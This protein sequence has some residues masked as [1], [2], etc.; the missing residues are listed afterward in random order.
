MLYG[1]CNW[2]RDSESERRLVPCLGVKGTEEKHN[3]EE[4]HED[5]DEDQEEHEEVKEKEEDDDDEEEEEEGEEE[6]EEEE[7]E[8]EEDVELEVE[9]V[10]DGAEKKGGRLAGDEKE[11]EGNG[12]MLANEIEEVGVEAST[13]EAAHGGSGKVMVGD[14]VGDATEVVDLEAR[15]RVDSLASGGGGGGDGDDSPSMKWSK[16]SGEGRVAFAEGHGSSGKQSTSVVDI[17]KKHWATIGSQSKGNGGGSADGGPADENAENDAVPSALPLVAK[18]PPRQASGGKGVSVGKGKGKE[19]PATKTATGGVARTSQGP[20]AEV[21][22]ASPIHQPPAGGRAP[23]GPSA[24]KGD[25]PPPAAVPSAAKNAV[26]ASAARCTGKGVAAENA[27]KAQLQLL[28]SRKAVQQPPPPVNATR[29]SA[30]PI[31]T[32]P[33]SS[34]PR[35]VPAGAARSLADSKSAL[36]RAQLGTQRAAA[37]TPPQQAVGSSAMPTS[38]N[39]TAP[40]PVAADV[41]DAAEMGVRATLATGSGAVEE[42]V[43][44]A[45]SAAIQA[46]LDATKCTGQPQTLAISDT[47]H[48]EPSESPTGGSA[49]PTT[50]TDAVSEGKLKRKGKADTGK[51]KSSSQRKTRAMSDET[52]KKKSKEIQ[53]KKSVGK[54][55]SVKKGQEKAEEN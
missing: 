30:D 10:E 38:G 14:F 44:N 3:E 52:R 54:E 41:D 12:R 26:N 19:I 55:K 25:V 50:A 20:N 45:D 28:A 13:D 24:A 48:V 7:E 51:G 5:G 18:K 27:L 32:V 31:V 39:V 1:C 15:G 49:E 6:E 42:V 11:G 23:S 53:E 37:P 43:H 40:T 29:R 22:A 2:C 16:G 17:V 46:H 21:A 34:A 35:V 4:D 36:L 9:Y 47:A 33:S 8:V